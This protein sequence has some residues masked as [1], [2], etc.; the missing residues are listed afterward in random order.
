M[1]CPFRK[2][3][4][5]GH[6]HRKPIVYASS[7]PH[8][9]SLTESLHGVPLQKAGIQRSIVATIP[10]STILYTGTRQDSLTESPHALNILVHVCDSRCHMTLFLP[11][12]A[13]TAFPKAYVEYHFRDWQ[14]RVHSGHNSRQ[15]SLTENT[16]QDSLTESLHG[17][18]FRL[19]S[20][21]DNRRQ[22]SLTESRLPFPVPAGNRVTEAH[23]LL[24]VSAWGVPFRCIPS[25]LS[26]AIRRPHCLSLSTTSATLGMF[27]SSRLSLMIPISALPG[28]P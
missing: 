7:G 24:F 1:E 2:L 11:A 17:L 8:Q 27:F 5:H 25:I 23:T 26:D 12:L 19:V 15:H 16:R 6:N 4:N 21:C 20:V 3:A 10:A 9:D 18:N 28:P 22:H 14:P 13:R